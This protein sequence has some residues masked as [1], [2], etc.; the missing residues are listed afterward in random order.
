MPNLRRWFHSG[1]SLTGGHSNL[2]A[3]CPDKN[4]T[5]NKI[6]PLSSGG[7]GSTV[8]SLWLE[9]SLTW[10]LNVLTRTPQQIKLP[11]LCRWM[12]FHSVEFLTGGHFNWVA[13]RPGHRCWAAI[14]S[15]TA[16]NKI[17]IWASRCGSTV[18][19]PCLENTPAVLLDA[20]TGILQLI[21]LPIFAEGCDST[22][23][24]HCLE[25]TPT[26]QQDV[27][28]KYHS[29]Y[30][31]P[32]GVGGCDSTVVSLWLEDTPTGRLNVLRRISQQIKFPLL[33]MWN[34]DVLPHWIHS[35]GSLSG[36]H[37]N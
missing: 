17:A 18:V 2:A 29:K 14:G 15:K 36:G 21:T 22:V 3:I 5:A 27:Q 37:S 34:V 28:K 31:C 11:Q 33:R 4:T 12:R 1:D 20:W 26:G 16:A 10:Q 23:V 30:N 6:C 8:M 9:D 25:D 35:G 32:F 19:G 7:C 13:G 24:S